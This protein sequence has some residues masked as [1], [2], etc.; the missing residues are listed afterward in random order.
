MSCARGARYSKRLASPNSPE[1]SNVP[2]RDDS[3]ILTATFTLFVRV[4][5]VQYLGRRRST[6][7]D[8]DAEEDRSAVPGQDALGG[9]AGDLCDCARRRRTRPALSRNLSWNGRLAARRGLHRRRVHRR[10][11]A[12]SWSKAGG[13]GAGD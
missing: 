3:Q 7:N 5:M 11:Q 10:K 1:L 4:G 12:A 6:V 2:E 9:V 13:A 8:G